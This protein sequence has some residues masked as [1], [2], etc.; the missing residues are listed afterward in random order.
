MLQK[1]LYFSIRM[2]NLA[3]QNNLFEDS[4]DSSAPL[5]ISNERPIAAR[6]IFVFVTIGLEKWF[7]LFDNRFSERLGNLCISEMMDEIRVTG[8]FKNL[9]RTIS[10][11]SGALWWSQNWKLLLWL[12]LQFEDYLETLHFI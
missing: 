7:K 10:D 5:L 3:I 8:I 2:E 6:P 1:K 11:V 4:K 9:V 12:S